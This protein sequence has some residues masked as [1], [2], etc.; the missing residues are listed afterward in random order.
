MLSRFE[1]F[2]YDIN[3]IDLYWHRIAAAEMK[4]YGLKAGTALYF[5]RLSAH[6]EGLTA[7]ELA[8]SCG[9]DKADVSRE[10]AALEQ[11]GFVSRGPDGRRGYRARIVLTERGEALTREVVRKASAAVE[12]VGSC[13][14]E[15]E[16]R[17]FYDALDKIT[18]NIR[19]LSES[20]LPDE[21]S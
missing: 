9:R 10:I 17:V 1:K 20:G 2:T 21:R 14:T 8:A 11:A 19:A 18:E 3:E 5:T 13:L 7:A 6:P 16:R 12:Q 15:E 4:V